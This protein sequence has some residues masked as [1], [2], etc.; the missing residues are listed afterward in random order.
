MPQSSFGVQ[1][2]TVRESLYDEAAVTLRTLAEIGYSEVELLY[3]H[4]DR[5]MPLVCEAGLRPVSVHVE[6]S[7]LSSENGDVDRK[8]EAMRRF[9]LTHVVLAW[10]LPH[11]RGEGL[12]FWQRFADWMNELGE[13]AARAGLTFGYH[14]H[15]FEFRPVEQASSETVFDVLVNRFD[16]RFVSFELDV[17]WA[18]MAGLD[19][20]KLLH[21]LS[22]R[23]PLMHLKDRNVSAPNEFDE[24]KVA[25]SAFA[26][27]GTGTLDVPAILD[28]ARDAGVRHIFVEQDHTPG[29]PL[30][31]LRRS[32]DYLAALATST[33][34]RASDRR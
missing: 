11:E 6:T 1:L 2:Y 28:A 9:G 19:P 4:L 34:D 21:R 18:E 7:S 12:A 23:V 33:S 15:A 24:Q 17:F 16:P 29:D 3:H 5:L 22:G 27:V 14:N 13:R 25:P 8:F 20:V 10:L 30:V 31:S 32:H 26:E